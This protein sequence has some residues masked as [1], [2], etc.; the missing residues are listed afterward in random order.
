LIEITKNY[1]VTTL[2][3]WYHDKL[4]I[5]AATLGDKSE[6]LFLSDH[7]IVTKQGA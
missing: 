3:I 6:I 4:I 5:D 1:L 2:G 7:H